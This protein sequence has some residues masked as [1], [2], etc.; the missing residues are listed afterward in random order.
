VPTRSEGRQ[1]LSGGITINGT[2]DVLTI[3]NDGTYYINYEIN[4]TVGLLL[5]TRLLINGVQAPGSVLSPA[6]TLSSYNNTVIVNVAAATT[7]SLQFFGVAGAATLVGGGTT[8]AS[9]TIIRLN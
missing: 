2:N 4:T 9:L 6:V 3:A 7:L 5:S 8:G 1:A